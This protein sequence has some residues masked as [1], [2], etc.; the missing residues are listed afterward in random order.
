[1]LSFWE[2]R[3]V[4]KN[5]LEM[6]GLDTTP[7][8]GLDICAT[9]I[10]LLELSKQDEQIK[11]ERYAIEP[12]EPGVVVE[13][14]ILNKERVIEAIKNL[15]SKN[16]IVSRKVNVSIPS[17]A[18]ISKVLKMNADLSDR[19]IGAEIEL[20]AERYI[21]YPLDEVNMDYTVLGPVEAEEG[22][23]NVLLVASKL[24]NV[25]N[26][27]E[28]ITEAGLVPAI[29]DIDSYAIEAA[30]ELVVKK[31]PA[32]VRQK[33]LAVFDIGATA[34]TLNV[35]NQQRLVHSREQSFGGQQIIDEIQHRYGLTYEE[36]IVAFQFQDLPDDY[37]MEILEPFKQT[38][39][40]QINRFCQFFFSAGE[41]AAIDYIFLTGGIS[42]INGLDSIIQNKTQTKTF[43]A[44]PFSDFL[45]PRHVNVENF[46]RDMPRLMN[47][48]G[49]ALR[50]ITTK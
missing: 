18:C 8:M 28:I 7:I 26:I 32:Q 6:F 16:K 46:K 12:L 41:Y 1:M 48:C 9:A 17:S 49:L 29:I 25:D 38:V 19:E 15:I 3:V 20:E 2:F 47:C 21:P 44:N 45:I 24:E 37:T 50:N 27:E 42:T 31:M 22:M 34:T 40:Q 4:K 36:A 13:R 39:A 43:L 5:I 10:K 23:V 30:F 14:N 35:F 33:V 11:V